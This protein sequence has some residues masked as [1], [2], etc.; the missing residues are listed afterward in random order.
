[1]KEIINYDSVI[2]RNI[3]HQEI[4]VMIKLKFLGQ[5]CLVIFHLR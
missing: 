1:M 4:F 3:K 5:S 2:F